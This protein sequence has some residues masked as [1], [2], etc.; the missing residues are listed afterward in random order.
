[1]SSLSFAMLPRAWSYLIQPSSLGT[2]IG[3]TRT[4]VTSLAR[5][6]SV[7]DALQANLSGPSTAAQFLHP[8]SEGVLMRGPKTNIDNSRLEDAIP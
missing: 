6:R 2:L 8:E 1:M 7:I 4:S 3:P 5:N